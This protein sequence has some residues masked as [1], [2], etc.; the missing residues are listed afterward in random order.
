MVVGAK[1]TMDIGVTPESKAL[2]L[3]RYLREFVK[4]RTTTVQDV[5]KYE[6][7]LWFADMPN[8]S[9]CQSPAWNDGLEAGASWLEV[10]KQQL[11]K[12]PEPPSS[13]ISWLDQQAL[14]QATEEIPPLRHT[15]HE[16]DLMAERGEGEEAPLVERQ[17]NDHPE[18]VKAYQVYRPT[19][20]AWS[21][22][23][24]RRSRIQAIYAELFRLHTQVQ[25]QGEVV[26]L[27][28]G[29]G[30]LSWPTKPSIR[31][32]VFIVR[33][34]LQFNAASGVITLAGDSSGAQLR[35]EDDMLDARPDRSHYESVSAQLDVIG[36]A[37]SDVSQGPNIGSNTSKDFFGRY[38]TYNGPAEPDPRT[39]NAGVVADG[40]FRIIDC[41]GPMIA[42]RAYDIYLRGCGI[43]RL[44]GELKSTMN[45]A[46][47]VAIRQGRIVSVNESGKSGVILSTVFSKGKSAVHPR[48]RG[49]RTFEEIPPEE[50]RAVSKHVLSGNDL[51]PGSDAHLRAILECYELKRLTTQVGTTLLDILSR[52]SGPS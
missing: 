24:R 44:G 13:I 41:E 42:K 3:A 29:V 7:V 8:E 1:L 20:I 46:L 31:R 32:H 19:W 34:D 2:L 22:E 16:P 17:L 5:D 23:Y 36:D 11:P 52:E 35:I 38:V 4:L 43:R 27:V 15:I 30:L 51:A 26:E 25:K 9:E 6:A 12:L 28:L 21:N 18:V 50:F 33:V 47:T 37:I 45:K 14:R 49:P 40:L 10:R 48:T 39:V